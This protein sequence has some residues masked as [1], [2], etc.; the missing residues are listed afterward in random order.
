MSALESGTLPDPPS[1]DPPS[2]DP[3][4]ND[5]GTASAETATG[6]PTD[7]GSAAGHQSIGS[8]GTADEPPGVSAAVGG[9]WSF[10]PLGESTSLPDPAR[11]GDH[12]S[13][14]AL[15]SQSIPTPPEP[16]DVPEPPRRPETPEP[17]EPDPIPA[18]PPDPGPVQPDPGPL[19]PDLGPVPSDVRQV[20][21]DAG[22]APSGLGHAASHLGRAAPNPS[23]APSEPDQTPSDFGSA[24]SG[25]GHASARPIASDTGHFPSGSDPEPAPDESQPTPPTW[26]E[27]RAE[28]SGDSSTIAGLLA[29]ALVAYQETSRDND[30][31]PDQQQDDPPQVTGP[32]ASPDEGFTSFD[33]LFDWRYQSPASGRHRSPE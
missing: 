1:S 27:R 25:L 9:R 19:A 12:H 7:S 28:R 10:A 21:P 4:S 11:P 32:G 20:A 3:P 30:E 8:P 6:R 13:G 29:E 23:Q 2:S 33:R 14:D 18:P 24:L 26:R 15:P 16:D 5:A 17:D 22:Q 31:R